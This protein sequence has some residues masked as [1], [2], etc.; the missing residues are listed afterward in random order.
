MAAGKRSRARRRRGRAVHSGWFSWLHNLSEIMADIKDP[1]TKVN[2]NNPNTEILLEEAEDTSRGH[3]EN[4]QKEKPKAVGPCEI[5][6]YAS[7]LD[8]LFMITGFLGALGNGISQPLMFIVFGE[9]ADSFVCY[10]SSIQ[11]TSA[12]EKFKPLPEQMSEFSLYYVGIGV[13]VILCG[14]VQVSFWVL[15]AARQ[16]RRMRE[17]FFHSVLSQEIS[18]FDVT[19]SGELNTRLTEDVNKINDG[20]GDKVGH[21]VQNVTTCVG[22]LVIG[23]IKGWQL[24]LVIL[25]TSPVVA[26]STAICSK[27]VVSL[28]SKELSA[29]AK[30]G[31]VAEEVLS[32]I[33]TVVAFGGQEKEI[34]RYTNNLGEAKQIGIKKAITSQL[35]A[36][37]MYFI[38]YAS[39]AL[40]FW[41]GSIL[42][43]GRNGYTI[44]DV[45]V[46]LFSV[47][48]SSYCVGQAASHLDA[49]SVA[50]G[51]AYKIFQ[52][53]D[54]VSTINSYSTEG[55]KPDNIKG[56]IEFKNVH[57]CY[58]SRPNV[59]VLKGF[60]LKVKSGQT[61]ALVGQSGCG[62]STTVQLL[63]RM[64]DP[65]EGT[66]MVDSHDI[67]SLNVRH[68]REM[69]GVV[70]QEPVLFA[71]T[72]KN[73]IKYG[74]LDVTDEEIEKAAKEANAYDFIMTLPEKFET[75]VGERGAQLSG[76]QKQR[77]AIA[78][79]LVRNPK[80]LLLDE[81]TS[82]LDTA[83]ESVVQA[84]LDKAIEGR[85]TIIIAH[86]LST[87]WTADLIVVVDNGAMA[88]QGT[89]SELMEKKGIYYSLVTAQAIQVAESTAAGENEEAMQGKPP[90]VQRLY[91]N[92][93]NETF[94]VSEKGE[95]E[96]IEE[97]ETEKEKL[98]NI[99]FLKIL[100]L[101]KSEWL[102]IL[103]GTLAAT[104]NGGVHP[105]FSVIFAKVIAIFGTDDDEFIQREI[106]IYSIIV[107][108]IGVVS[109][110]TFFLQGFMF[111]RSGEV[112]TMRLRQ[113]AFKSMLRQEIS[114]FDDKKNSTGALTTRLATDA[115][116]IQAATGSRLGLVAEN[117][118][119][120]GVGIIV[121]FI[122]GW[123]MT[124]LILV[125]TPVLVIT[126]LL[127]TRALVGFA[128]RDKKQLQYAGK[129]A[130]ETADNIRTVVSLTREETFEEMYSE[131]LQ[132]PFRNAQRKAQTY[133][134]CF[135][136]SQSFIHFT[137]AASYR[138]GG[139]MIEIGRMNPEDV[140]LV[141]SCLAYGA[142]TVGQ[143]LSF[144]PDYA[145]AKSAASHLFQL[146]NS[147]PSIDSYS[148][149]GLKPEKYEGNSELSK[150][151]FNYPSRP[152]VPVLKALSVAISR[153]QTVAFVG[154]SGC[155]KSTSI[156]LLQ[157][158][159]DPSQGAVLFDK[160][161]A[162]NLNVQ[163]L[164][165]QIG[166]VSQEPVLFDRSIAEN[167]AYGDNTREVP[168]EEIEQA[169][170]A[171]NIHSFI[172]E[173]PEK[174]N[175]S[176]GGKG[177]QL[178]GGQKQRIAI[179]RALI[180]SP[181]VLLLDE[182]TSALDNESE[183][184]VQQALDQARKGRTC[185]MIAHRLSTV[186]NADLIVVMKNGRVIEK[187]T[188][189]QLLAK[190]GEYYDL[191]NAQTIT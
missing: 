154:S 17:M 165:N 67:R 77:I 36:G 78:R 39:Y 42:I 184:V 54:Q 105:A 34:Q 183:K 170:K 162:N 163:W 63:Q 136:F 97:E 75:L 122:F 64:Y 40:G 110:F 167:I 116:Q 173:L 84:A 3:E 10:N 18:W 60:N 33:R 142:L 4:K 133:G 94:S 160:E 149:D 98:P 52:I 76:G 93:S 115:S 125:M 87:V 102:Y 132:K 123:E 166:I 169:A 157:R 92:M 53:I 56:N 79:A 89:H 16:T 43:L 19:K 176:V 129:I 186:Q 107:T 191:V 27:M 86:R 65:Q 146:F 91:S 171:A 6:R 38:I 182:A 14:Y 8:I 158:F 30:A 130:S 151:S 55:Y 73:N 29:Y 81:A 168:M 181:K 111:G 145:K 90:L 112:L 103:I 62:K 189:Q 11:N 7:R 100:K 95:E 80:V 70:S 150:V 172:E 108:V 138:F 23:L 51:A 141:F 37:C 5:F 106:N 41:Y 88:E 164:R 99:S 32:S 134:I 28:T 57:F 26:I 71:T 22:G 85:T 178:S 83:S 9:M 50:R 68:Y 20:I 114:W 47:I 109:F 135:A 187:G 139:Y 74:R 190:R 72:I 128:N 143:T 12:C 120:M 140:F 24:A 1:D 61:V 59:Q 13:G 69:I 82:A 159:Y 2:N 58:P 104:I 137:Y 127:E 49:F 147:E 21:L 118:A 161:E 155:G 156:Q 131:S 188:H 119:T 35:A 25:A 153:G 96:D 46:V 31:S 44:G 185:I 121:S 144:A 117:F 148:K 113:M 179:A 180:R 66:I 175:T 15:A 126:G 45:F 174:Y 152:D 48:L 101:N 124:L 177:T